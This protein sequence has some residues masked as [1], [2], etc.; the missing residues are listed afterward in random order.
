MVHLIKV[1]T[2]FSSLCGGGR[3]R[4]GRQGCTGCSQDNQG[5]AQQN[6]D[7]AHEG[8]CSSQRQT[9][10]VFCSAP[11]F[12]PTRAACCPRDLDTLLQAQDLD[13]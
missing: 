11:H 2:P 13:Y 7:C 12:D 8:M 6:C 9:P 4:T 5:L 10:A 3:L 1:M